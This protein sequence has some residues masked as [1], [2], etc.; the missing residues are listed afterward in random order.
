MLAINTM[1]MFTNWLCSTC[2]KKLNQLDGDHLL[3]PS[4]PNISN[5]NIPNCQSDCGDNVGPVSAIQLER[6]KN[7]LI[8]DPSPP[9]DDLAY[10]QTTAPDTMPTT[11][12]SHQAYNITYSN[13][14][15][16]NYHVPCHIIFNQCGSCLNRKNKDNVKGNLVQNFFCKNWQVCMAIRCQSSSLLLWFSLLYTIL[17]VLINMVRLVVSHCGCQSFTCKVNSQL[18]TVSS[19]MSQMMLI[20]LLAKICLL[21]IWRSTFVPILL[22]SFDP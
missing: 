21:S 12:A 18:V 1:G 22:E 3:A 16:H 5:G 7:C 20:L 8:I 6:L 15:D 17:R 4:N 13:S 11:S 2:Y 14:P 10:P 19:S 9:E